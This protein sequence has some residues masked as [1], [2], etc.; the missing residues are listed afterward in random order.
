M[1]G[2]RNGDDFILHIF[3]NKFSAGIAIITAIC[4]VLSVWQPAVNAFALMFLV[5]PATLMLYNELRV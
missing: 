4:T 3:R 2:N 5:I 1:A